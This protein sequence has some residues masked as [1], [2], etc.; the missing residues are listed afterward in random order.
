VAGLKNANACGFNSTNN[1]VPNA[2]V[3]TPSEPKIGVLHRQ[4]GCSTEIQTIS[5]S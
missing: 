1:T 4:P 3:V 5:I 2:A